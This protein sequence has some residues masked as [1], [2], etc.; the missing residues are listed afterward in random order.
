MFLFFDLFPA[1]PNRR[2]QLT[3]FELRQKLIE[4]QHRNNHYRDNQRILM[5]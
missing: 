4:L 3:T 2:P 1:S 5:R